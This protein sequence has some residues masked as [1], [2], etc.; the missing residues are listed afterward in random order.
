MNLDDDNSNVVVTPESEKYISNQQKVIEPRR[1][2]KKD[3]RHIAI[4]FV[5]SSTFK[6]FQNCFS[7]SPIVG[8]LVCTNVLVCQMYELSYNSFFTLLLLLAFSRLNLGFND[9]MFQFYESHAGLTA[10]KMLIGNIKKQLSELILN[11][12]VADRNNFIDTFEHYERIPKNLFV[13]QSL[14]SQC[15]PSTQRK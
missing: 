10:N 15:T 7:F 13:S 8:A 12:S 11:L 4:V 9:L 1:R 3:D 2:D 6:I 14:V 5:Y